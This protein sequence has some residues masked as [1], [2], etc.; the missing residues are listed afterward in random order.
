MAPRGPSQDGDVQESSAQC[1][2]VKLTSP[3]GIH[4]LL[5]EGR[6]PPST[7][8][9]NISI[10]IS[11]SVEFVSMLSEGIT[12][13]NRIAKVLPSCGKGSG[14]SRARA[15]EYPN[16]ADETRQVVNPV[17]QTKITTGSHNTLS[18]PP[19]PKK[20]KKKNH[21]ASS[22]NTSVYYTDRGASLGKG[23][24]KLAG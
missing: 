6:R 5:L 7:L 20:K 21:V 24:R 11:L 14:P 19:P 9:T 1:Y 2:V 22:K 15:D 4:T 16:L 17:M 12:L 3:G 18:T 8:P 10:F 13:R 23:R